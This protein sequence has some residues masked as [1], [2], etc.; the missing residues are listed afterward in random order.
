MSN[1]LYLLIIKYLMLQQ[2]RIKLWIGFDCISVKIKQ[3]LFGNYYC[4]FNNKKAV[5]MF[6]TRT[7]CTKKNFCLSSDTQWTPKQ[8]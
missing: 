5:I 1:S 6:G 2:S 8:L 7:W 3:Y 4:L